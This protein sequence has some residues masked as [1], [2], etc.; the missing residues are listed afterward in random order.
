MINILFNDQCL[1]VNDSDNLQIIL[2]KQGYETEGF[3]VAI[4]QQFIPR[5]QY[6]VTLLKS[7]D[8]IEI[9]FP[10]QGG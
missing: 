1:L 8:R 5:S 10:M 9:I 2:D 6:S 4:N 7:N 3:A